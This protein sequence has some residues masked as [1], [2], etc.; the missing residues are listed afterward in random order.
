MGPLKWIYLCMVLEDREN[1]GLRRRRTTMEI[2][3]A[4]AAAVSTGLHQMKM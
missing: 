1:N 4:A 2:S 3:A